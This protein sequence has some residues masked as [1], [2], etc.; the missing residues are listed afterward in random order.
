M[1][2][3]SLGSNGIPVESTES[4]VFE[5]SPADT[6]P[7]SAPAAITIAAAPLS[8]SIFF[9]VNPERDISGYRIYRSESP[10]LPKAEWQLLTKELLTTNTF[11]DTKI[12]AGKT[13]YYYLTAIDTAGNVSDPSEVVSET[14]P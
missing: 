13:Y 5:V 14:A 11:Q 10:T 3:V 12:E 6:F 9:A 8:L 1:R 7:P 2:T 4:N